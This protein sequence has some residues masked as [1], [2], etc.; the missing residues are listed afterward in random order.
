MTQAAL[1][2]PSSPTHVLNPTVVFEVLSPG[3]ELYDRGE[4]ARALPTD[5]RTRADVLLS[6]DKPRI[7][8]WSR[9]APS[10]ESYA[11]YGAGDVVELRSIGCQPDLNELHLVAGIAKA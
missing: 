10:T 7:E 9:A 2:D 3:T 6:Q 8:L 1:L 5:R 11:V 4:K